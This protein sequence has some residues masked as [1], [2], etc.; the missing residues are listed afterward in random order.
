MML[1]LKITNQFHLYL[2]HDM[3]YLIL[4]HQDI[5]G[6]CSYTIS[7]LSRLSRLA[8]T[9]AMSWAERKESEIECKELR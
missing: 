1:Y 7:P 3:G 6:K 9:L 2:K 5:R 4:N 8:L